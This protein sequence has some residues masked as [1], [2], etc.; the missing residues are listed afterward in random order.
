MLSTE[1]KYMLLV[2]SAS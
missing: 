1:V 2:I